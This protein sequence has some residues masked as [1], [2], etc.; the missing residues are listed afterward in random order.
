MATLSPELT[1]WNSLTTGRSQEA[2]SFTRLK[3]PVWLLF[4]PYAPQIPM[5][6]E[7]G[8]PGPRMHFNS[9]Q[10]VSPWRPNSV[11]HPVAV[12]SGE[13]VGPLSMKASGRSLAS[14]PATALPCAGVPWPA[15][16][17]SYVGD[18]EDT[19][20]TVL[21]FAPST[22]AGS[23]DNRISTA[24]RFFRSGSRINPTCD[25][26]VVHCCGGRRASEPTLYAEAR[27]AAG[28][29]LFPAEL[30]E[31]SKGADHWLTPGA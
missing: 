28:A 21:R 31:A 16:C 8:A 1:S 18:T 6:A 7:S 26:S 4:Q 12:A 13:S 11:C 3:I 9:R 19:A 10:T 17:S 23:L 24:E 27:D 2:S 20:A 5:F 15:R 30:A 14:T 29:L 22:H 25:A